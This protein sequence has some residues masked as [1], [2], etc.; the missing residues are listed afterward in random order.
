MSEP[1]MVIQ[2]KN[3]SVAWA[4][5][6]EPLSKGADLEFAPLS[7][8]F[9]GITTSE[10]EED[11][12]VRHYLDAALVGGDHAEVETVAN[13]IFP[14][15][16]WRFAGKNRQ[17]LYELYR[18]N[19]PDYVRMAPTKNGRGLYFG[20]LMGFDMDPKTGTIPVGCDDAIPDGN[21]LE[22]VISHCRS[23]KRRSMFQLSVFDPRRDH[24]ASSQLGFP[25]LQHIQL[26]PDFPSKT[27]KLNAFYATQQMFEKAYGNYLGLAR[28]A[29]FI[30]GEIGLSTASVTCFVGIAKM[31]RRPTSEVTRSLGVICRNAIMRAKATES[32]AAA[33]T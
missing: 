30:A 21:Q 3:V 25:C 20:R 28:L 17:K 32:C 15:S 4:K 11:E 12:E 24:T 13:T 18:K 23:G 10:I 6:F 9:G 5:A 26:N 33:T 16:L 29:S 31:E 22:F 27:L 14:Q 2:G 1:M 8:S 19:L 7:L